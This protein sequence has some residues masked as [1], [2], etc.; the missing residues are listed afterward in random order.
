MTA[1]HIKTSNCKSTYFSYWIYCKDLARSS[2]L[3]PV[4]PCLA[5]YESEEETIQVH[6]TLSIFSDRE[7]L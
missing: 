6:K 1:D 5:W 4:G 3:K 7:K 2:D